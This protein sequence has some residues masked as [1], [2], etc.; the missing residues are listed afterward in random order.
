[1]TKM[2]DPRACA[3]RLRLSACLSRLCNTA[4]TATRIEEMALSATI[5]DKSGRSM[6]NER[7]VSDNSVIDTAA[8]VRHVAE[9][10]DRDNSIRPQ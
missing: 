2:G 10:Y 3:L 4:Q 8:T 9:A 1:M 6:Q 7:F 5:G